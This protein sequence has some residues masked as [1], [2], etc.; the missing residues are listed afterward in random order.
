MP[1]SGQLALNLGA[2]LSLFACACMFMR[3]SSREIEKSSLV[4]IENGLIT[5]ACTV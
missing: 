1:A 2:V 4:L 5:I 3:V